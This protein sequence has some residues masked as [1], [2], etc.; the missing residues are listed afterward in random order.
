MMKIYNLD[1]SAIIN[2]F[3]DKKARNIMVSG[4]VS[5][6]KDINTEIILNNCIREGIITIEDVDKEDLINLDEV[7]LESG[8]ITR[9]SNTDK[10]IIALSL[11]YERMGYDVICV[12]DDYSMQNVLKLLNLKYKSVNTKGIKET[13]KWVIQCRGCKK[14][15]PA[16]YAFDDCEICGS[17]IIRKRL[18]AHRNH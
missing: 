6:I 9:L 18:N 11:K 15:Y 12:T 10:D 3:Y 8:D 13:I 2:G 7:L 5:E 14:Q 1:A 17:P 4:A 16:D